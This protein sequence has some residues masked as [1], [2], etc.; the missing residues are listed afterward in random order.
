MCCFG[1]SRVSVQD[2]INRHSARISRFN[3]SVLIT[4]ALCTYKIVCG[5]FEA[6]ADLVWC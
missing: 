2:A 5:E 4:R 1:V 6:T 3:R